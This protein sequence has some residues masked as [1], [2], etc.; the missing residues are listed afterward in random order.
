M[1]PLGDNLICVLSG[2]GGGPPLA[3]DVDAGTLGVLLGAAYGA[4][5]LA[6][7]EGCSPIYFVGLCCSSVTKSQV[8]HNLN[9][10][11]H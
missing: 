11:H 5:S 3:L 8:T 1:P 10:M 2:V 6:G 7:S 9:R 4:T